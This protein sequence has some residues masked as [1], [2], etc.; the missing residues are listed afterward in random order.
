[1]S[2]SA[3]YKCSQCQAVEWH[4]T[5]Y[6]EDIPEAVRHYCYAVE[7]YWPMLRRYLAPHTGTGSSGEKPK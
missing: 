1:M 4:E 3:E 7:A 6:G 2:R 5:P